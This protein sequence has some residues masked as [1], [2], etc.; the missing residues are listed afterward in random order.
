LKR[1]FVIAATAYL[2]AIQQLGAW[3]V[4]GHT[5][6][7][8][9]AVEGITQ[10]GPAF[11]RA[12]KAYIG[13]LATIP[14]SWRS[15]SEPY[16]RISEDANHGWYTEGFDFIPNP[17]HSRTEFTLRVYDEYLKN[18]SKDPER[19]KLLNI[20]YTG[21]Q[22]YSMIEGYERMKAGMR[23]YRNVSNPEE[24]NRV[25]IGSIYAAISPSLADRAQ[26]QQMLAN[27]I[28]FY[29]GWVGH[30][31]AD[32]AQPLHNSIHHD[33]WSGA[34]PK[35]YTRDPNIHGRFESQYLDLIGVTEEDVVKYMRKEPRLLDNVW[36]AVLDHSLEARGFTE[37]VYRLDLRGAFAKKDDADA[38]ELVCKRLAAGAGF[39]RDLAYTAW[40]ESAKPL[41]RVDPIDLP[42]NPDNPK[43][44]P[45][46]GSAPAK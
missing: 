25:N 18:K 27:D 13:H 4:R 11:L 7:N 35:G 8:L 16:L 45:A 19:A 29:M 1:R 32:A 5:V 17:P 23:L 39:L 15:P 2:F 20:R 40:I 14:D 10:D 6:A 37:D 26:V 36:K 9:A 46:T 44:N 21:L 42:Q 22:A 38:R 24:A 41:P 28:A 33:G 3:G 30:Y 43:Y 34:D 31:V 12:Q